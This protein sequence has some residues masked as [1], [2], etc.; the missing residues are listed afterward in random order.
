MNALLWIL[1]IF[2]AVLYAASGVMMVFMFD[3]ISGD[4]PSF[5]ALPRQAWIALGIIELVCTVALI[6]PS[7][8]R[9]HPKLT[10]VA[11]AILAIESIVFVGVHLKYQEFGSIIMV[12]VLGLIMAFIAYGRFSMRPIV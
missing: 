7:A 10:V 12:C 9:W 4:V 8:V 2:A 6:V 5:A 11:A 1:Q 3:Q